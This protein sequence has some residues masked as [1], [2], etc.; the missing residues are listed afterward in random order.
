MA[1]TPTSPEGDLAAII[2][3]MQQQI[4]DLQNAPWRIPVLNADPGTTELANIWLLADGRLR[5]RHRNSTDTA[6]VIREWVPTAAGS[7]TSGS[8]TAPPTAAPQTHSASW[9]ATWSASYRGAGP[10]RTDDTTKLFH[11]YSGSSF[12]GRNRAYIGFP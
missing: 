5:I 8:T 6:W 12:N 3:R 7:A 4:D 11:G 9:A 2:R 10:Q 1:Y